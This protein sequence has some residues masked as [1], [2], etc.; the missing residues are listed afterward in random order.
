MSTAFSTF[1]NGGSFADFGIGLGVG[2][3]AGYAGGSIAGKIGSF[4][5]MNKAGIG[6]AAM[7]GGL[8]GSIGGMGT[9]AIYNGDIGKGAWQGFAL[10]AGTG[11]LMW[12]MNTM[13]TND[14][15]KNH[16]ELDQSYTAQEKAD[17]MQSIQESGQSPVGGRMM[18][19]FIRSGSTLHLAPERTS[20]FYNPINPPGPHVVTGT[21]NMYF[22]GNMQGR[23]GSFMGGEPW[24]PTLDDGTVFTHELG[25]TAS[26]YG[27]RDPLNVAHS[28]N[29]YRGWTGAPARNDYGVLSQGQQS[30]PVRNRSVW[31]GLTTTW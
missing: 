20:P 5:D 4:F 17:V 8:S 29:L 15:I 10:G 28:E 7:R 26:G 2:I 3:V 6:L 12:G 30:T 24:G 13:R 23:Y 14:F 21:N 27:L 22:D 11:S 19:R 25:H 16:T 18:S 9:A 1:A 31:D